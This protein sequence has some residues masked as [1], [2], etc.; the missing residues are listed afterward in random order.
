[1]NEDNGSA[2]WVS[3][4]L[5]WEGW[6]DALEHVA[7]NEISDDTLRYYWSDAQTLYGSLYQLYEEILERIETLTKE[8]KDG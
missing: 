3:G 6:P 5:E 1:V 8:G 4:I 7:A 2:E